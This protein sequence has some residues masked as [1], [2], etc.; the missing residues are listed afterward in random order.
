MTPPIYKPEDAAHVIVAVWM[1]MEYVVASIC[2]QISTSQV[3]VMPGLTILIM[4]A[5]ATTIFLD[6]IAVDA[7]MDT[8]GWVVMT[9]KLWKG[10]HKNRKSIWRFWNLQKHMILV[11]RYF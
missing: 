4:S 2:Q 1:D 10:V 7:S 8:M 3:Y 11:I 9:Q 6:T 5:Y